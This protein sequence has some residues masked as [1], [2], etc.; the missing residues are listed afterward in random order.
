MAYQEAAYLALC[1]QRS[2]KMFGLSFL[3]A[4]VGT[5]GKLVGQ[6]PGPGDSCAL[7]DVTKRPFCTDQRNV[8]P[9]EDLNLQD[10]QNFWSKVTSHD[11]QEEPSKKVV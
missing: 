6:S 7:N 4:C 10:L 3:C 2:T 9:R 1:L 5:D 8:L 11:I